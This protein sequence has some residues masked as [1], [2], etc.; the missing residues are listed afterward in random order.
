[1]DVSKV[2]K[3]CALNLMS[4]VKNTL[5][6]FGTGKIHLLMGRLMEPSAQKL[7]WENTYREM[8]AS[9]E[10][11][12]DW[13]ATSYNGLGDGEMKAKIKKYAGIADEKL[14]TEQ[15]MNLTRE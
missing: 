9:S 10:N 7:S 6:H 4:L 2:V 8:A 1:M 14:S 11:W 3:I 5:L 13:D 12:S 15:I